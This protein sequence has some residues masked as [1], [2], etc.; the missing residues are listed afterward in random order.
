[1][2][3]AAG[4]ADGLLLPGMTATLDIVTESREDVL[5]I[6][7]RAL[8]YM[9]TPEVLAEMRA[10]REASAQS[11][12]PRGPRSEGR[13]HLSDESG[14]R[15]MAWYLDSL[16]EITP[17]PILAGLSDGSTTEILASRNLTEG[18]QIIVSGTGTSSSKA[19][20]GSLAKRFGGPPGG[21][22]G[23]FRRGL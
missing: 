3:V 1:V 21:P 19:E 20:S 13:I 2:V 16:G 4:N 9:P 18:M 6:P 7:T 14:T 12:R 11:E 10:R 23:G 5:T 15:S 17:A 8:S 22:G